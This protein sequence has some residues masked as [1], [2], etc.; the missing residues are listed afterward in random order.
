MEYPREALLLDCG[1]PNAQL[2]RDSLG[3]F[4]PGKNGMEDRRAL[5]QRVIKCEHP[6][7]TT[8]AL[9]SAYGWDSDEVLAELS[10]EEVVSILDRY[11]AGDLTASQVQRWAGLLEAR[12]DVACAND[13][14]ERALFQL[15]NP[16]VNVPITPG[17]AMEMRFRLLGEAA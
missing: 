8:L 9:L 6:L 12:D 11:L 3:G 1:R 14:V 13:R 7:E 2:M 4:D 17:F 10:S 5:L 15:A 16:E